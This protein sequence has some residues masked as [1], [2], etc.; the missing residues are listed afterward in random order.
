MQHPTLTNVRIRHTNDARHIFYAVARNIL[1]M[2]TRRL[3]AEERRAIAS[4]CVYVWE[5]RCANSEPLVWAWSAGATD[6]MGWGPSRVRD[7]FLFYQQ[8]ENEPSEDPNNPSARWASMMRK[9]NARGALHF[10]RS[11]AD[12]LIKQTYSDRPRGITR[13][14]HLTAYFSQTTLDN[15]GTIDGL[16]SDIGA[17]T[18]EPWGISM[19]PPTAI[20]YSAEPQKWRTGSPPPRHSAPFAPPQRAYP[21]PRSSYESAGS[22]HYTPTAV[23]RVPPPPHQG[24]LPNIHDSGLTVY[25]DASPYTHSSSSSSDHSTSPRTFS[26]PLTPP[27]NVSLTLSVKE[28][29]APPSGPKLVPIEYLQ[30]LQAQGRRRDPMDELYLKRFAAPER[31]SRR[32]SWNGAGS[33]YQF[34]DDEAKSARVRDGG[35]RW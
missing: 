22:P 14:W 6:G 30:G 24:H 2:T 29:A 18:H 17:A 12:R 35:A 25:R 10:S 1:P 19:P 33:P 15:L 28:L 16:V 3:D 13:K 26:S 7:E 20:P 9:S 5:E 34:V 31:S 4:G 23:H 21:T 32:D 27:S 11:E 8:R